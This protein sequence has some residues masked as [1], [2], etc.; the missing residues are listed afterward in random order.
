MLEIQALCAE[1]QSLKEENERMKA[2]AMPPQEDPRQIELKGMFHMYDSGLETKGIDEMEQHRQN[3]PPSPLNDPMDQ[4]QDQSPESQHEDVK[5][6]LKEKL[7]DRLAAEAN[8]S[9]QAD[10]KWELR[11]VELAEEKLP[12]IE[13]LYEAH[14]Q[15]ELPLTMMKI[16]LERNMGIHMPLCKM[17]ELGGYKPLSEDEINDNIPLLNQPPWR[18]AF[19]HLH[20]KSILEYA[21]APRDRRIDPTYCPVPRQHS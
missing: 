17:E 14:R 7:Q 3:L 11:V 4:G 2:Q 12:H 9:I 13:Q 20:T 8:P 16:E 6:S 18:I 21:A 1:N 19:F 15:T 10:L 5:K